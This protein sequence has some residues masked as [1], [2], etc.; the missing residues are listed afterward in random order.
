MLG[1]E[2]ALRR[3][4]RPTWLHEDLIVARFD[5]LKPEVGH[6]LPPQFAKIGPGKVAYSI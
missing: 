6:P 4:I 1:I 3:L 2:P 5:L